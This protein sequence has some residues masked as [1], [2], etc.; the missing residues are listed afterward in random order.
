MERRLG[1]SEKDAEDV[2]KQAFF[3]NIDWDGLLKKRVRPPFVPSIVSSF[4]VIVILSKMKK[5]KI[6]FSKKKSSED[7]SNFDEEFTREEAIL[8]PT[9]DYRP[10][11]NDDQFKFADFDYVADW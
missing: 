3:K 7:V 4:I 10:I 9:K 11:S 2:K 8:T 1:S 5:I 6:P